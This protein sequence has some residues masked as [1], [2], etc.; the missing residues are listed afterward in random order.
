MELMQG[1]VGMSNLPAQDIKPTSAPFNAP[2]PTRQ[3]LKNSPSLVDS[4]ERKSLVG[5]VD[6]EE[7]GEVKDEP[8]TME[9]GKT[10]R[11][12]TTD[13]E[14]HQSTPGHSAR[15]AIGTP[16]LTHGNIATP[17]SGSKVVQLPA[18]PTTSSQRHDKD[19]LQLLES[20]FESG[21]GESPRPATIY[22]RLEKA[23]VEAQ[24]TP[25]RTT[26]T[27]TPQMES[28]DPIDAVETQDDTID[29]PVGVA[30][31]ANVQDDA[32]DTPAG[33]IDIT[34]DAIDPESG[35]VETSVNDEVA[36]PTEVHEIQTPSAK[37]KSKKP[38]PIVRTTKASQARISLAHGPKDTP[39]HP[40]LGR[41]RQSSA[42]DQSPSRR[43]VSASS[44]NSDDSNTASEKK[45][46][47]IPHSKPRPMSMIFP[48][49]PP[50]A[51]SKKAPTQSTF[52]LPGEVVAAKLK[53]AKEARTQKDAEDEKKKKE[54]KARPVPASMHR[55]LAVRQT[56]TSKAR[57]SSI[58]SKPA[59]TSHA[60]AQSVAVTGTFVES[61]SNTSNGVAPSR[62]DTPRTSVGSTQIRTST[63]PA[64]AMGGTAKGRE[65]YNRTVQAN[66]TAN[67]E[68]RDKEDAAKKARAAAAEWGRQA[69]RD[70][71]EKQ[72][73]K[74]MGAK[75]DSTSKVDDALVADA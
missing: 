26:S 25:P 62:T 28:D 3:Q 27:T 42:Q 36:A 4:L 31:V 17:R 56:S 60:R 49:P 14:N 50:L 20:D 73:V 16:G 19:D 57:T 6:A 61:K 48:T 35:A 43:V 68:K 34:D 8:K 13:L 15:T 72:R 22:D 54:F 9:T 40:T 1:L 69:S 37:P 47:V 24:A 11:E 63:R 53:A 74:K 7:Q 58:E 12:Q 52:Q 65:V 75:R 39:R 10:G 51:K 23:A 5:E 33:A 38:A 41:P 21:S 2:R 18:Q 46:V 70:W 45:E 71:A 59:P 44:E 55:P 32:S 64:S 67:K 29:L 66:S 30:S